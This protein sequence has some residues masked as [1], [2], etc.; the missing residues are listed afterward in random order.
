M[1]NGSLRNSFSIYIKQIYTVIAVNKVMSKSIIFKILILVVSFSLLSCQD[2]EIKTRSN[3]QLETIHEYRFRSGSARKLKR[4][5]VNKFVSDSIL[6]LE[7]VIHYPNKNS[8]QYFEI[9]IFGKLK[10]TYTNPN[11]D[12]VVNI[13][14]IKATKQIGSN[15][16]NR[17]YQLKYDEISSVDEE[18]I[19]IVHDKLG[20]LK[21]ENIAWISNMKLVNSPLIDEMQL[22]SI[23]EQI[24]LQLDF[25]NTVQQLVPT[26]PNPDIRKNKR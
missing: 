15:T 7:Y 5:L 11:N 25:S 22:Y 18:S 12:R 16:A 19:I 13:N 4:K 23:H 21:I 2:N 1:D 3:K 8:K 6:T 26:P 20:V 17:I 9:P 24:S 14:L 10:H